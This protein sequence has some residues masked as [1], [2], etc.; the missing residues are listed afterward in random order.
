M[1][2]AT[3]DIDELEVLFNAR[4]SRPALYRRAWAAVWPKLVATA[5]FIGA[6]QALVWTGW[7]PEYILPSPFTVFDAFF[8][9]FGDLAASAAVTLKRGLVGYAIA[10]VIGGVIGIACARIKVLRAGIGSMITGLQT[11]PSVAWVPLAIV[12]FSLTEKAILFVVI[13]GAAPSIANGFIDGIDNVPPILLR[14]GRVLGA[15][16][17]RSLRHVVIP[18]A[19]PSVVGGLKQGWAFAW[20]SLMA[21]ELITVFPGTSGLGQLLKN[22]GEVANYVGVYEVMIMIFLIGVIV[23]ALFFGSIVR[24]IRR[25]YGLVDAAA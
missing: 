10:I 24:Y 25:R 17:T 6:W 14:A 19:L 13:L 22:E 9:N 15:R 12:L 21:A 7:K 3:T 8:H 5:I 1:A 23:D 4:P 16:G 11:M 2:T 20:R 18:A